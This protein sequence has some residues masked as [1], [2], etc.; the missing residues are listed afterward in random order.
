M[1]RVIASF[2]RLRM[3]FR[4]GVGA[5]GSERGTVD[6]RAYLVMLVIV[7]VAAVLALLGGALPRPAWERAEVVLSVVSVVVLFWMCLLTFGTLEFLRR[8]GCGKR[9]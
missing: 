4:R 1:L 3:R 2:G 7:A 6:E 5:L 8:C 9:P